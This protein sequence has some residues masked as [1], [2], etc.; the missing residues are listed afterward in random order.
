[1]KSRLDFTRLADLD[2][3]FC[4]F[5]QLQRHTTPRCGWTKTIRLALG[6]SSKALGD[7]LGM[8]G[9]GVRKL[10]QAETDGTITLKTLAR[11]AEGLDCEVRY[12]LLPRTSLVEQ[13]IRRAQEVAGASRPVTPQAG[14]LLREVEALEAISTLLAQVNRRG[15]W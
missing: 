10:E 1:V 5:A 6:M 14:G 7:R 4:E 15:F 11:L 8:T 13:V 9:Q 12:V 2:R 3:Q